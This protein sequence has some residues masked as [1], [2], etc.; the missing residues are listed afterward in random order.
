MDRYIKIVTCQVYG[1]TD[2]L[3]YIGG[4]SV[5]VLSVY[6]LCAKILISNSTEAQIWERMR[7]KTDGDE[8]VKAYDKE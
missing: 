7:K 1:L 2:L 5:S 3:V 6:G 8:D 4:L